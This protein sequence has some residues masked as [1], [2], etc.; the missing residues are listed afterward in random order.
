MSAW[1]TVALD[2]ALESQFAGE[3]LIALRHESQ[4]MAWRIPNVVNGR[5]AEELVH[6]LFKEL[7]FEVYPFG[8]EQTVTGLTY[9]L[10]E[11][12]PSKR[13]RVQSK[14]AHMPD[15]VVHHQEKGT[16]FIEVK[17]LSNGKLTKTQAKMYDEDTLFILF[18]QK[19][20]LCISQP[21]LVAGVELSDDTYRKEFMLGHREEFQFTV[22]E[23]DKIREY[24][25]HVIE[26]LGKNESP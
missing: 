2:I 25:T 26:I 18:T 19:W 21:E 9:S 17:Y 22:P 6:E 14:I 1:A 11:I 4:Y 20:I 8:Y 5:I 7:G 3:K 23:K 12:K 15:F 24:C 16:F 13:S 10:K